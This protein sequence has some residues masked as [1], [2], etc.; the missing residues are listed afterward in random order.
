MSPHQA[1]ALITARGWTV[2][3]LA[4]RWRLSRI[5]VS[6]Q[7]ND[8][9]RDPHWNDALSGLPVRDTLP[10]E[11]QFR[12]VRKP[13]QAPRRRRTLPKGEW[14]RET[15]EVGGEVV[16]EKELGVDATEGMRG[17]VL[18]IE[19]ATPPRVRILFETGWVFWAPAQLFTQTLHLTG[20]LLV[21]GLHRYRAGTDEEVRRDL[22]SGR[23][24]ISFRP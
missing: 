1:R 4:A 24:R 21:P 10:V 9:L 14:M 20:R 15:L 5:W 13:R 16:V 7:I 2:T 22:Q 12:T 17:V 11:Q 19:D 18:E 23:L 8:P 3:S 6:K